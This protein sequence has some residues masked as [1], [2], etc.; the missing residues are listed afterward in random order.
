M[1]Q[2]LLQTFTTIETITNAKNAREWLLNKL[3]DVSYLIQLRVAV[4]LEKPIIKMLKFLLAQ[5][6]RNI[7]IKKSFH[8]FQRFY[9]C[10]LFVP[11]R[12]W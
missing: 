6:T 7:I 4:A 12:E 8:L 1:F 3:K 10:A 2:L 5:R 11:G 9:D